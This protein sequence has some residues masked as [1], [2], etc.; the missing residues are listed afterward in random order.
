MVDTFG[1]VHELAQPIIAPQENGGISVRPSELVLRCMA[2]R[3][4]DVWVASCLDFCL[5][6]QGDSFQEV[7]GKLEEQIAEYVYDA[8]VGEDK[9]HGPELLLRR[10]PAGAMLKYHAIKALNHIGMFKD[11]VRRLF[12]ESLPLGPCNHGHV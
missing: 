11:G 5:A 8:T 10:A 12:N 4:G 7:K 2:E 1:I 9:E 6:V 3:D